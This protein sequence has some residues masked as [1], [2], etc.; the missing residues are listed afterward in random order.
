MK[1]KNPLSENLA[2]FVRCI[3]LYADLRKAAV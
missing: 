2:G 3:Q 1:C